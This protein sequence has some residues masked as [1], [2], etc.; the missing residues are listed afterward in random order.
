MG[1]SFE[2]YL[3]RRGDVLIGR[4]YYVPLRRRHNIPI[5]RREDEL[6]RCLGDVPLRRRWV[7]HLRLTCDVAETYRET[8]FRLPHDILLPG[9]IVLRNS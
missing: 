1:V 8:S 2:T 6:L 7:F 9:G 3:R 4:H 5:R